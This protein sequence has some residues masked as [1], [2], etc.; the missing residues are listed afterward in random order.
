MPSS[1]SKL[2]GS[3]AGEFEGRPVLAADEDIPALWRDRAFD[4][5]C[6]AIGDNWVRAQAVH[7]ITGS[8]PGIPFATLIHPRAV[9]A[10]SATLGDGTVVMAGA[11][12]NPAVVVGSHAILN[13]NSSVDHD[14]RVGDFASV[15]PGAALGGNVNLGYCA[16][17]GIGAAINHGITIGDHTVIGAG[18]AVVRNLDD[19]VLAMGVPA[20]PVRSREPDE[21]YL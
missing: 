13:T 1:V 6:V 11:I 7:R 8:C 9:I 21:R 12:V 18:A 10:E 15:A 3:G 19:R 4:I 16:Y 17:V 20:K 14:C 5:A 2:F